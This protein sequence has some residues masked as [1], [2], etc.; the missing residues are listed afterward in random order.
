MELD[1]EQRN[2]VEAC[3]DTTKRLVAITGEAGTGKTTI[4]QRACNKLEDAQ[5]SFTIAAPTGKAA[6]RIREATGYPA[7]TIH[8]LLAFNRP[9]FD[10]ET[11]EATSISQPRYCKH[12][13][14]EYQVVIVDE[15]AMVSSGLHRDLVDAIPTGGCLRVFG[16]VRQLPPIENTDLA[17]PT[18]PFQRCLAKPNTFTLNNIYRQ[19]EG[20][21]IIEAARRINRGQFFTSNDDVHVHMGDAVLFDLYA[22]LANDK[23]TDWCSLENQIISPARKS[24]V[25]TVRLNSILQARFNSEMPKRTELPRN[26]WEKKNVVYVSVGDKVVCNTNSYDLRDYSQRYTEYNDEGVGHIGSFIPCPDTKQMLNGEVG[27]ILDIDPLGVL[28][29]DFGDRVVEL[30]P[31]ILDFNLRKH[32]HYH[33]DPRKAIELA[34]ALTTHKC[35]GSQY[36]NIIYIMASC[37]FFNLS[38]PNFYTGLTRAAK[39]A[40]VIT[41]KR[42]F[43]TSLNSLGWKRKKTT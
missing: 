32:F 8:K 22:L 7:Q 36:D 27:R 35:Q 17:D 40:T 12:Y 34:Y 4:I 37:A 42:S 20:N 3:V 28:E 5:V 10:E 19:A 18:S 30:P 21:G 33:F 13:P 23:S 2:A 15:Y 43:A 1:L 38:R 6:R 31:K 41:D 24:D 39:R 25:G 9:D 16:D 11:G 29:I 26:K 14:L